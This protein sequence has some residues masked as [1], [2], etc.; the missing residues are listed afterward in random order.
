M[1]INHGTFI[2]WKTNKIGHR[3]FGYCHTAYSRHCT[4]RFSIRSLTLW[5]PGFNPLS[6]MGDFRHHI[7]VIFTCL[8]VKELISALIYWVKCSSER[9]T[10]DWWISAV[11]ATSDKQPILP[12]ST[13]S[14]ITRVA[15]TQGVKAL[16]PINPFSAMGNFKHHLHIFRSKSVNLSFDIMGEMQ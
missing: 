13:N 6:A 12:A 10:F 9:F 5:R 7:I 2:L 3:H 14:C 1:V 4:L 8:G 11:W 16:Y 15:G